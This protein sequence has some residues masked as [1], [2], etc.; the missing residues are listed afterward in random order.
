MPQKDPSRT[1]SATQKR[2]NKARDEGNVPKSQELSKVLVLLGGLVGLHLFLNIVGGEMMSLFRQFSGPRL[3]MQINEENLYS[4]FLLISWSLA[5]MLLPVFLV[6]ALIAFLSVRI[7]VGGLWTT[8]VFVPKLSKF[9]PISGIK[10]I[11]LSTQTIVRLLRSFFMATAVGIATYIILRS[12]IANFLPLFHQDVTSIVAYMLQ[13]GS[14]MVIYALVPMLIVALA[15]L[16]Y[17]MW[18]YEENLKMTKDEVKDERKQAEG[19]PEIKSSQRKK[20]MNVMQQ[21]MMEKVPEA[22]VIVTNPTHLAVAL[23]YDPTVSPAPMVVAKGADFMAEKIKDL[24]REHNIPIKENKPLAQAL[25]K[26]VEIGE[27]IPEELYQAVASLLAQLF[28][29]RRGREG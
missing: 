2:R 18:D 13:T 21:R 1:E 24:A 14:T 26:S 12:E 28:K 7:Q 25:Y 22:D 17:T 10:K 4:L 5:K 6:L 9:N 23:S 16:V 11:L 27:T 8:K 19:N 15:D 3:T 20:M 29:F